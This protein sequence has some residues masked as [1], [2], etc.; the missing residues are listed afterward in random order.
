MLGAPSWPPGGPPGQL[1][2]PG[3]LRVAPRGG[4]NDPLK[5]KNIV[6][7]HKMFEISKKASG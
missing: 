7:Q 5:T 2:A 6:F 3:A 1:G 4:Q